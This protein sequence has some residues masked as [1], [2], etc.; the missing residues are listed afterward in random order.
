MKTLL[1]ITGCL[2]AVFAVASCT[3]EAGEAA[4]A[5]E[6]ALVPVTI[7]ASVP[8]TRTDLGGTT[9]LWQEGDEIGVF[10]SDGTLCPQPFTTDDDY[11]STASF[12]GMK[13]EYSRLT[14]AFY[15]Y[16]AEAAADGDVITLNLPRQQSGTPADAVMV[17]LGNEQNGFTF[18][19]VCC[20]VK[21]SIPSSMNVRQVEIVRNDQ[22]SGPF[23]VDTS[24]SPF[25]VEGLSDLSDHQDRRAWVKTSYNLSGTVFLSVL[26]SS[27]TRLEMALTNASGKVGFIATDF[28][29]GIPYESGRIKNLGTIPSGTVFQDAALVANPTAE[30]L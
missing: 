9:P 5:T 10:T 30:Q 22:V 28:R 16:S 21:M 19:N 24:D 2:A 7:Q 3:K 17:S 1:H 26:P 11:E 14:M 4:S 20:L 6:G 23:T 18:E 13:P 15:P 8:A 27:S 25:P 12:A 29:T